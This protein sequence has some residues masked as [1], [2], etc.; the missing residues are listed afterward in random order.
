MENFE[1]EKD[2]LDYMLIFSYNVTQFKEFFIAIWFQ[3]MFDRWTF[4]QPSYCM[5]I[6]LTFEVNGLMDKGRFMFTT[7]YWVWKKWCLSSLQTIPHKTSW[8]IQNSWQKVVICSNICLYPSITIPLQCISRSRRYVLFLGYLFSPNKRSVV[9]YMII[10][11]Q[12]L[13]SNVFWVNKCFLV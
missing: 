13:G 9:G 10:F 12:L 4:F 5:H 11:I 7:N 1:L 8:L 3:M 6:I 2:E